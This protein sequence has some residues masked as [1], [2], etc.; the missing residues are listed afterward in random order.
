MVF[1]GYPDLALELWTH[2]EASQRHEKKKGTY[3]LR[4]S[5]SRKKFVQ[6]YKKMWLFTYFDTIL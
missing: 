6:N 5:I 3:V 1:C 4:N 2:H